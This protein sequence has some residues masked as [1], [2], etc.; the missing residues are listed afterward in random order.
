VIVLGVAM[1]PGNP[2]STGSNQPPVAMLHEHS[3]WTTQWGL[4]TDGGAERHARE[5]LPAALS[6]LS[7]HKR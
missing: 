5:R 3:A 6:Q 7:S 1:L 4:D 2:G